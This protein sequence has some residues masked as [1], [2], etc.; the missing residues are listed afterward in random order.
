MQFWAEP[1]VALFTDAARADGA[2]VIRLGGEYMR[3]YVWDCMFAGIHFAFSG[4]FC[5]CG[6]SEISFLH[7]LLAI[8]LVRVPGAYLASVLF[9]DTLFPMGLATACGSVLSVTICCVLFFVLSRRGKLE[10]L[11][12]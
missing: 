3:G 4:Y 9:P 6:R 1:A 11:D 7:N 2:A 5:A 10:R 12:G 8:V